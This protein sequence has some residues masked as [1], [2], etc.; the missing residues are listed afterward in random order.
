MVF[1]AIRVLLEFVVDASIMFYASSTI[2]SLTEMY[3]YGVVGEGAHE[4]VDAVK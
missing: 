2:I 1:F 3:A 4:T